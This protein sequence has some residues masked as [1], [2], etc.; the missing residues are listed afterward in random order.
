M[1]EENKELL[2]EQLKR[3]NS[4]LEYTFHDGYGR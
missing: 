3:F 1:E 2:K 4:I